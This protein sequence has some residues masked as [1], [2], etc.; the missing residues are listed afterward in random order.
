MC[1]MLSGLS[2][3]AAIGLCPNQTEVE[4]HINK[5]GGKV[6]PQLP[7]YWVQSTPD[8]ALIL[9]PIPAANSEL[10]PVLQ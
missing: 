2:G 4:K 5:R 7:A 6:G 9:L 8:Y 10:P 3:C 1:C